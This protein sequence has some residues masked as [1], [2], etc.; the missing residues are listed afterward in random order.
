MDEVGD[1]FTNFDSTTLMFDID[2]QFIYFH[3]FI[4]N[5]RTISWHFFRDYLR[6]LF[7]QKIS[8]KLTFSVRL[9]PSSR[10]YLIIHMFFDSFGRLQD[11]CK[12]LIAVI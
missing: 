7:R 1:T 3:F 10:K 2:I 8:K 5:G 11:A 12:L 9:V 6:C 4:P